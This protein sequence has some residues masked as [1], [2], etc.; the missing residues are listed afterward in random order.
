[1]GIT[2]QFP[3]GNT[4]RRYKVCTCSSPRCDPSSALNSESS[5]SSQDPV[6][7][8]FR[9]GT[10]A[11]VPLLP[12]G[13]SGNCS[14][15]AHLGP[16]NPRSR[17]ERRELVSGRSLGERPVFRPGGNRRRRPWRQGC[18]AGDCELSR[19]RKS[20]FA[21]SCLLPGLVRDVSVA[22]G[23]AAVASGEAAHRGA[24]HVEWLANGSPCVGY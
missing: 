11:T 7:H 3:P 22:G 13:A 14:V 17:R 18:V 19:C 4:L 1:M 20:G 9:R 6:P 12:Q 5:T 23:L 16:C 2:G 10:C 24:V 8:Q 15:S 21:R